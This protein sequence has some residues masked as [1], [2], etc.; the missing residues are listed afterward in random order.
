MVN[1]DEYIQ[2]AT[3]NTVLGRLLDDTVSWIAVKQR[4][5]TKPEAV[6]EP[7]QSSLKVDDRTVQDYISTNNDCGVARLHVEFL[8]L[9]C[10]FIATK[11]THHPV[12]RY[13]NF[14]ERVFLLI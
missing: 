10:W 1:K 14:S 6:L 9:T 11:Q 5:S 2:P 12:S 4:S 3:N 13:T 7:L 8:R